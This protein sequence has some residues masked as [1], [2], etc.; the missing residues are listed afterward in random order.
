MYVTIFIGSEEYV[1]RLL[2]E[3]PPLTHHVLSIRIF[4]QSINLFLKLLLLDQVD[5]CVHDIA[6]STALA[7][8]ST[9]FST[10]E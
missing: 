5:V 6:L 8:T 3:V 1:S 9:R 7:P 4:D 2:L 10:Y